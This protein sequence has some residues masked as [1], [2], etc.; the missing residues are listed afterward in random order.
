[1]MHADDDGL[2]LPPRIAPVHVVIIP[3]TSKPEGREAV[4]QSCRE[5]ADAIRSQ[6]YANEKVVVEMDARDLGGG[7]K[8]WE[9]IKKGVPIRIELGPRD[10]ESKVAIRVRRDTG[11]K[12]SVPLSELAAGIPP[13]LQ[14]IQENLY[15][16]ALTFRDTHTR[17][18]DTRE[19]FYDFF[20]PKNDAKPE[21]HG[22]FAL[23]HWNG[24]AAVEEQVKSDLK[25]T[26]RC[27]P[28]DDP[29]TPTEAGACVITG[30][31]SARR[32]LWA[33]SY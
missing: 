33:K 27:I 28:F 1:M 4:L 32:V 14:S 11:E 8:K 19:E 31:S 22:G 16:R 25:V 20:T 18:I 12:D 7:Q 21:M 5:L 24:N 10:L 17:R 9:S 3:V 26:I 15:Q 6:S 29:A 13:L 30:G 23:A 2:I